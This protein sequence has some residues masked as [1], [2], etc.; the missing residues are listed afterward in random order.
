M[1][2]DQRSSF[3]PATLLWLAFGVNIVVVVDHWWTAYSMIASMNYSSATAAVLLSLFNAAAAWVVWYQIKK[4]KAWEKQH[5][6]DVI[7]GKF[8]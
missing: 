7:S 8:D 3:H 5:L 2:D 4:F 6:L 1:V